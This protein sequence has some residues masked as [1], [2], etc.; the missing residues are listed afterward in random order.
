M[1]RSPAKHLPNVPHVVPRRTR[2]ILTGRHACGD[3]SRATATKIRGPARLHSLTR[4]PGRTGEDARCAGVQPGRWRGD[5]DPQS[6]GEH[7]TLR[8]EVVRPHS[9]TR[10]AALTSRPA[11]PSG[12]PVTAGLFRGYPPAHP[13]RRTGKRSVS[14][15]RS[16]ADIRVRPRRGKGPASTRRPPRAG[17]EYICKNRGNRRPE[18]AKTPQAPLTRQPGKPTMQMRTRTNAA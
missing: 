10:M 16:G 11:T 13:R 7:R 14:A 5:D 3:I 2:P 17:F 9:A 8:A 4:R 18:R 6:A 12:R 1:P 15:G